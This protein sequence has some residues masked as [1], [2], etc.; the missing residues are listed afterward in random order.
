MAKSISLDSTSKG[1]NNILDE[2][3]STNVKI[4][5]TI[6]EI[7]S[8]DASS[9][10]LDKVNSIDINL[11]QKAQD[12][13]LATT[14][15]TI[16]GAINELFQKANSGKQLIAS[17]IGEDVLNS[18]S[19]YE[20]IS[21]AIKELRS[22]SMVEGSSMTFE[23]LLYNTLLEQELD[24]SKYMNMS[25]LIN[26][27]KEFEMDVSEIKQIAC[28]VAHTM[29]LKT[30]GS[31]YSCGNNANGQLGLGNTNHTKK[32]TKVTANINKDVDKVACGSYFTIIIKN[33]GT[34]WGAGDNQYGQLGMSTSEYPV[35]KTFTQ[36]TEN[37]GDNVELVACGEYYTMAVKK[38]GSL[39]T[40]GY[41]GSG[42]LGTNDTNSKYRFTQ[43]TTNINNDVKDV[44]CGE[45]H[46]L[47]LKT[48]G[49]VWGTGRNLN[50]QLG[51][52]NTSDQK[53]FVKATD[54]VKSIA[55]NYYHSAIIK[56]DNEL[57]TC[58]RNN[59][60]QLGFSDYD[61]KLIFS[62]V[63]ISDVKQVSC[64]AEF[65]AVLKKDGTVWACGSNYNGQLGIGNQTDQTSFVKIQTSLP[66]GNSIGDIKRVV[67]G[68]YHM[69]ILVDSTVY[70]VGYNSYGQL[71]LGDGSDSVY[72]YF[73]ATELPI[74]VD[75]SIGLPIEWLGNDTN[76]FVSPVEGAQY[77]F[78]LNNNGYYENQNKGKDE[79]AALCRLYIHNPKNQQVILYCIHSSEAYYDYGFVSNINTK[80]EL[81][82]DE[83]EYTSSNIFIS[84]KGINSGTEQQCA[85]NSTS[86]WYYIKY[87]KDTSSAYGNDSLQF[88]VGFGNPYENQ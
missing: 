53:V 18:E 45:E 12:N 51:I 42:Q 4:G 71:G 46:T 24:V 28:G 22:K 50:G 1:L 81:T 74:E 54:N 35:V 72:T 73:Q 17:T 58:G 63:G 15:K 34:V 61:Q 10:I 78:A 65:T 82:Y 40:C 9:T 87:I 7:E 11:Y 33:D 20:A 57:Y 49:T 23:E 29:I 21:Q 30:D 80:L 31:L 60:A 13:D 16:V 76:W 85:L 26:V 69:V 27:I 84:F 67:C 79:T 19:T 44:K 6:D 55:C 52:G 47:I 62:Q 36:I 48:D 32:I 83:Y 86:G 88:R 37:I 56:T 70:T 66:S 64:G 39:W 3:N 77:G 59:S 38:D 43:V 5:E 14:N 68:H 8:Q 41:N 75:T 2:V 25:E